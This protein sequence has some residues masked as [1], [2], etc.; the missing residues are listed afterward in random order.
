MC[1]PK[2]FARVEVVYGPAVR[3][4]DGKEELRRGMSGVERALH[5]VTGPA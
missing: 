1:I 5:E 4:G 3:V 2:P